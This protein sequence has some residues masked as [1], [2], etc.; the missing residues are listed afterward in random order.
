LKIKVY[1][2]K[3]AIHTTLLGEN[4]GKLKLTLGEVFV[5]KDALA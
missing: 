5:P 4:D 2:F 1:D 3:V